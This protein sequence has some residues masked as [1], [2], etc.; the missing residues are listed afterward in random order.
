MTVFL[1]KPDPKA[2]VARL[3]AGHD[4]AEEA[5]QLIEQ[6]LLGPAT[7]ARESAAIGRAIAAYNRVWEE[8]GSIDASNAAQ[9]R[10]RAM[11]AAFATSHLHASLAVTKACE[12]LID[13]AE[14]QVREGHYHPTLV[15]AIGRAKEAMSSSL[16]ENSAIL[17]HTIAVYKQVWGKAGAVDAHNVAQVRELA[18]KAAFAA[19][20]AQRTS[21]AVTKACETLIDYAE[22]QVREGHYHPTLKSVIVQAKEAVQDA[23]GTALKG[24]DFDKI[25]SESVKLADEKHLSVNQQAVGLSEGI[26][27]SHSINSDAIMGPSCS[28]CGCSIFDIFHK[29]SE[30]AKAECKSSQ[31]EKK[32]WPKLGKEALS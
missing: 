28:C 5:A 6:S 17:D 13:Y 1:G 31:H 4:V 10:K 16:E 22:W 32:C 15:S 21:I 8:S 30:T 19:V 24:T 2:I 18:M 26:H 25:I 12:T 7:P 3:R 11:T 23:S 20:P 29:I 27:P 14:W 9:I